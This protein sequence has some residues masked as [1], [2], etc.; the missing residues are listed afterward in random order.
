MNGRAAGCE[1]PNTCRNVTGIERQQFL[2]A[3]V[4]IITTSAFGPSPEALEKPS[5]GHRNTMS[6]PQAAVPGSRVGACR[7]AALPYHPVREPPMFG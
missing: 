4:G 5:L 2:A 7:F 3:T 1:L 6:D